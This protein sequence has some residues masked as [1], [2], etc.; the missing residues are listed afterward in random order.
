MTRSQAL[1]AVAQLCA[2]AMLASLCPAQPDEKQ[3][4]GEPATGEPAVGEPVK[5]GTT[6]ENLIAAYS[7]A[8]EAHERYVACAKK[9][10][11]EGYA[12]VASLFR[13]AAQARQVH[14][15]RYGEVIKQLKGAPASAAQSPQDLQVKSTQENLLESLK[16]ETYE[17]Q[18]MCPAFMERA[19]AE[20]NTD[21]VRVF[22]CARSSGED[23]MTFFKE[24]DAKLPAMKGNEPAVYFVCPTCGHTVTKAQMGFKK[25]PICFTTAKMFSEV[26]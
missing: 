11:E 17:R 13:A 12:K 5:V 10:D 8:N 6:L 15:L 25:C 7:R 24:A 22:N 26:K 21:A 14:C 19:K 16:Q 23:L 9:A 18:T 20:G 2:G 4:A 3:G 1:Q